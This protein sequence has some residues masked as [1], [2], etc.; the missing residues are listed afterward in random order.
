MG[1]VEDGCVGGASW[2]VGSRIAGGPEPDRGSQEAPGSP[3]SLA[4]DSGAFGVRDAGRRQE[5]VRHCSVGPGT[6][7]VGPIPGFSREQTP[8]VATLH[9]LFRRLDVES[10]ESAL[11][12][13]AQE[14]LGEGEG[15]IAI[16]GKALRG[17]HGEELPG[18]R[19]VAA[20]A[21]KAAWW[22]DKRGVR[23]Q[24]KESELGVA[25]SLLAEL[26][27]RE[28]VVTGDALYAQRELSRRV[29]E[30]GGDY[31]WALKD[32]QPGV[33]E[34]VS[35]LFEQP[36]WGE[37]FGEACQEGRHGDRW[38]R[39]RLWTLSSPERVPG[40][41]R[42]GRSA[43]WNGP[44]GARARNRWSGPTPSPACPRSGRTL[45]GCWRYGGDTGPDREPGS[46]GEGCGFR[47]RPKPGAKRIGAPTAGGSAK[48]GA[49]TVA[50]ERSEE[51]SGGPATLRLETLGDSDP[52]R[53]IP[54]QLKDPGGTIEAQRIVLG[55][56]AEFSD[57]AG[58]AP[59]RRPYQ[60]P[61][62]ASIWRPSRVG[63][64]V[65]AG[66]LP[67]ATPTTRPSTGG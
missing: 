20:Y 38:E 34:A 37:R 4:G 63:P 57:E 15:T 23:G 65:P 9:H 44:G 13:W 10:F 35:L 64:S 33:K 56:M 55:F 26:D 40:L 60:V 54:R 50:V 58:M 41:A 30:Q 48:P 66:P 51:H 36:P 53:S 1:G 47:G 25:S 21:R 45:P 49:G 18:V 59:G 32:N 67:S 52:H 29:L 22:W 16:D 6:S 27:L 17:V 12:R 46:L 19:L 28:K 62:A 3:A 11:S 8:C 31:F 24:C 5:P 42:S 43:V 39:R 7:P 2:G 61:S 14:C